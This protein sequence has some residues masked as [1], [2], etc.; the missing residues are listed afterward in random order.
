MHTF[1]TV[2][3]AF[4]RPYILKFIAPREG[5]ETGTRPNLKF[6]GFEWFFKYAIILVLIHHFAL[7]FIEAFTF[8]QFFAT[9]LR[10]ILSTMFTLLLIILSQYLTL[11][12]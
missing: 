6:F 7:F 9:L 4:L 3:I 8:H 2:L 1:A 12:R 5:Y 11:K 10:V